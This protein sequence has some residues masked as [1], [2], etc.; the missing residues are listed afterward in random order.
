MP[1]KLESTTLFVG[2]GEGKATWMGSPEARRY[3]GKASGIRRGT[4]R[5]RIVRDDTQGVR[6][7]RGGGST[8]VAGSCNSEI[9]GLTW[10]VS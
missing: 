8:T 4:N 7:P 5:F 10:M 2:G 9:R 1:K 3:W 6:S